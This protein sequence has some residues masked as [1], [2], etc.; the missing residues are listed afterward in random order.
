MTLVSTRYLP[1]DTEPFTF[2][3]GTAR[4]H[5][6]TVCEGDFP[7][8]IHRH[9]MHPGSDLPMLLRETGLVEHTCPHG[10]GH[11]CPDSAAY[12]RRTSGDEYWGTHGCCGCCFD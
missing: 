3:N 4:V 12:F 9:S 10:V 5:A 7:C 1:Q 6:A 8:V 2:S 11:P